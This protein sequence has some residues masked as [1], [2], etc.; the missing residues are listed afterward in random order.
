MN[1]ESN[2]L[3][4]LCKPCHLTQHSNGYRKREDYER[5][6][7]CQKI[8]VC[9]PSPMSGNLMCSTCFIKQCEKFGF[10]QHDLV[11][12]SKETTHKVPMTWYAQW[13]AGRPRYRKSF[14]EEMKK[15]ISRR[16]VKGLE[17]NKI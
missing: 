1:N 14:T 15:E 6:S 5:C 10:S 4:Y 13:C 12:P 17:K 2:N 9:A 16:I 7:V 3:R 8:R 11:L